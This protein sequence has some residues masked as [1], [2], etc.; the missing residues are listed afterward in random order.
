MICKECGSN[1]NDNACFCPNCGSSVNG[2]RS[3]TSFC[4]F[5]GSSVSDNQSFCPSCGNMIKGNANNLS[6]VSQT[7]DANVS[8]SRIKT[9]YFLSVLFAIITLIIRLASQEKFF[10]SGS[11]LLAGK[12]YLGISDGDTQT[13]LTAIPVI[14]LIIS[15]L[16]VIGDKKIDQRKKGI[17]IIINIIFIVLSVLFIWVGIPMNLFD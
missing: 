2:E 3:A 14:S 11:G 9:S 6:A 15:L 13:F 4:P 12:Y 7:A 10:K 5:C 17:A 1:I 8:S 16:L